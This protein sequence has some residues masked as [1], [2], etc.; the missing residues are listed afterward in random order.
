MVNF[1]AFCAKNLFIVPESIN[2]NWHDSCILMLLNKIEI[3]LIKWQYLFISSY[4]YF[5]LYAIMV[6]SK[7]HF[8]ACPFEC[9]LSAADCI[10]E[11]TECAENLTLPLLINY[12]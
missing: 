12:Y 5:Y 4:T 9:A 8:L 6:P 3:R 2:F 10:F 11:S 7:A 1:F